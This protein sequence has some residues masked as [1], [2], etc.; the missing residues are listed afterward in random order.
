MSCKDGEGCQFEP[1]DLVPIGIF[2][3]DPDCK[4]IFWNQCLADW[5]G[6]AAEDVLGR[7]I[8]KLYPHLDSPA[9]T[10]RLDQVFQLG[11]PVVF[12][13]QLHDYVIPVEDSGNGRR[14]QQTLATP[15]PVAGVQGFN[16]LF[17]IQDVTDL[18]KMSQ[19]HQRAVKDALE[20]VEQR[21][22]AEESLRRSRKRLQDI[23][24]SS[25]DWIWEV[26]R[27]LRYTYASG[28]VRNILGYA[29]D[30]LLGRSVLEVLGLNDAYGVAEILDATIK[31]KEAIR[32]LEIWGLTKG[33]D[34]IC[35]SANAVPVL[36][37]SGDLV[38]YRGVFKNITDKKS[39]ETA[40]VESQQRFKRL[41]EELGD[42]IMVYSHN[43]DNRLTYASPGIASVFGWDPEDVINQDWRDVI[44]FTPQSF[45]IVQDAIKESS[46]K[47]VPVSFEADFYHPDGTVHSVRVTTYPV[48]DEKGKVTALEGFCQETTL[49]RRFEDALRRGEARYAIAQRAADIC[50]WEWN[51]LTDEWFWTDNIDSLLGMKPGEFQHTYQA[52]MEVV[53]PA[54]RKFVRRALDKCLEGETDFN[55]EHRIVRPSGVERWMAATGEVH[56]DPR[57]RPVRMYGVARDVTQ[58][59]LAMNSQRQL[60]EIIEASPE[61]V[62]ICRV[63]D[64]TL[65][66]MNR[67]GKSLLGLDSDYDIVGRKVQDFLP[68]GVR[69]HFKNV[70]L[71]QAV[72]EGSWAGE[73]ILQRKDGTR[74][75]SWMVVITHKNQR[76]ELDRLSAVARDISALKNA[77]E[78]LRKLYRAVEQIA[79]SIVITTLDGT[80][81]YVNPYFYDLTGYTPEEVMGENPAILSSGE[82]GKEF[83]N[84]LWETINAGETWRGEICNRK[85]N[86]QLYWEDA[87][88]SPLK[89][90]KGKTTHFVAVK[91]DVTAQRQ[92][93]AR[94]KELVSEFESVFNTSS[95]AIIQLKGGRRIHRVNQRFTEIFGYSLEEV[96][97]KSVGILHLSKEMYRYFG[98]TFFKRLEDGGVVQAEYQ[99]KHKDGH[100]VW[101]SLYGRAVMPPDLNKGVIWVADDIT[102]RKE[103]DQLK[104]D[105]ERMMRHD[106]KTPLNAVINMPQLI[107]MEGNLTEQQL[108]LTKSIEESGRRMLNMIDMSLAFFKMETGSYEMTPRALNLFRMLESL[109]DEN[110]SRLSA[111][112]LTVEIFLGDAPLRKGDAV[113][114]LAEELLLYNALSNVLVNAIEASPG[115]SVVE[116][117]VYDEAPMANGGMIRIEVHNK[118]AVPEKI[119]D[120]FFQKYVTHGKSKG[121]GLGTYSAKLIVETMGGKIDM[122]TSDPEGTTLIIELPKPGEM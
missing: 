39:A 2:I 83:F 118:G 23:A 34:K 57:G 105:V 21:W 31:R 99:L 92:A 62:G 5:S 116:I 88:I 114:V 74:F 33:G 30:E 4:V 38:G 46:H 27:S 67:A 12:S 16:A 42:S 15:Y 115:Q 25:A 35:L 81:E 43:L 103:L 95:V 85:K 113:Y 56:L 10:S 110:N 117:D 66:Y 112:G 37:D 119:R 41:V 22:R 1:L 54:D 49:Q 7:D 53:H 60:T 19:K 63:D 86:G 64:M 28:S 90:D 78:E 104:V 11:A 84:Q 101:C 121:T 79:A 17:S 91:E 102:H 45:S 76:G 6:V 40:L 65:R 13:S 111:K 122:K 52:F 71:P 68:V 50:S 24:L 47:K 70:L 106:L 69:H 87:S 18:V 20:E 59:R 55:I 72:K 36:D 58:R 29:P 73:V 82:H 97:R 26:D 75:P 107:E 3:L 94:L 120:V 80:I 89:N 32:D 108:A 98:E 48:L 93:Q 14:L 61:L 8:R 44:K 96:H 77:T 51:I 109:V 100:V 9:F